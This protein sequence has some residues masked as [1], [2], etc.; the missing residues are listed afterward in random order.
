[1][2][3]S[4][5]SPYGPPSTFL[6]V[7]GVSGLCTPGPVRQDSVHRPAALFLLRGIRQ[8]APAQVTACRVIT[9]EDQERPYS[10]T[11]REVIRCEMRPFTALAVLLLANL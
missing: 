7:V 4:V 5:I 2:V 9:E 11:N 10:K 3:L 1:V 8:A 6:L